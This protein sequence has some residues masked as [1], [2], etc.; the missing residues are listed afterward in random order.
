MKSAAARRC[1]RGAPVSECAIRSAVPADSQAILDVIRSGFLPEILELT[2]YGCPGAGAYIRR[3]IEGAGSLSD[4]LYTVAERSGRLDGCVEMRR[5]N[6][7]LFLNYIAVAPGSRERGLG[8]RL[9][10]AAIQSTRVP[11]DSAMHLDVFE[12]N[13]PA[14]NWYERL[15]FA[16]RNRSAFRELWPNRPGRSRATVSQLAQADVCH[17]EFGFSEIRIRTENGLHTVGRLGA[18][19]FRLADAAAL[20]DDELAVT[21]P[22]IDRERRIC[23]IA[24][25]DFTEGSAWARSRLMVNSLRM[26]IDL[27]VLVRAL[28]CGEALEVETAK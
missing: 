4:T 21:L 24:P 14:L 1:L 8:G 28:G 25:V 9:L 17:R 19:W 7:A 11:G 16:P 26:S 2:I 5:L 18:G 23:A 27:D 3:Q 15:G 20:A 13:R 12:Q 6:R 10:A 22:L